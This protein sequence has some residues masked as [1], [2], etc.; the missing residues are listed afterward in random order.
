MAQSAVATTDL[1]MRAGPGPQFP[2]VGSIPANG[3]VTVH[4]CIKGGSWCDVTAGNDRGWSYAAYLQNLGD[5]PV[6]A[7]DM[8]PYWEEHYRNRPF[9]ARRAELGPIRPDRPRAP[10]AARSSA[11]LSAALSARLSVP[12]PEPWLSVP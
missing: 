4:G 11:P 10:S 1:N 7:F 2:I 5:Q 9:F 6:V 12:P 8:D 3:A